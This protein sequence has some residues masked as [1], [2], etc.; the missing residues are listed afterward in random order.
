MKTISEAFTN[1][2]TGIRLLFCGTFWFV[3]LLVQLGL[4]K[5]GIIKA[6]DDKAIH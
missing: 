5:L 1:V 6:S 3:V 2:G 4:H